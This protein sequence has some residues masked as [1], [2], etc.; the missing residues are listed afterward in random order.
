[1]GVV[2][3]RLGKEYMIEQTGSLPENINYAVTGAALLD[4]LDT[5][6]VSLPRQPGETSPEGAGIAE[7]IQRAVVPILCSG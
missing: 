5:H 6:A 4:F 1:M 3:A 2:V 7:R